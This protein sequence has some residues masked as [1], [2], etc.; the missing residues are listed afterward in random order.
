MNIMVKSKNVYV[1]IMLIEYKSLQLLFRLIASNLLYL[2]L[3]W[4][5]VL[6]A[7]CKAGYCSLYIELLPEL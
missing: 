2:T 3:F 1:I 7:N 5:Y 4:Y 6:S